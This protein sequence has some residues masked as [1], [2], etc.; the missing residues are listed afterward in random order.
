MYNTSC[1]LNNLKGVMYYAIRI[2]VT[3]T[4]SIDIYIYIYIYMCV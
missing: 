2:Y 1:E 4:S 3:H